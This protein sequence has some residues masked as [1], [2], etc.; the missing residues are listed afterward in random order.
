MEVL[1]FDFLPEEPTN[2]R[3]LLEL[4]RPDK[5]WTQGVVRMRRLPRKPSGLRFIGSTVADP[6]SAAAVFNSSWDLRLRLF[7]HDCNTYAEQLLAHLMDSAQQR[8]DQLLEH[9]D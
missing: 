4:L 1:W 5:G 7:T 9:A 3:T 2:P 6:E 8:A